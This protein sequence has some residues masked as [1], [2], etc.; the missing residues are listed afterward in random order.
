MNGDFSFNINRLISRLERRRKKYINEK[1]SAQGLKG[2]M[3][4][5]LLI[6]SNNP[7]STQDF[8]AERMDMD[9]SNVARMAREL[10]EHGYIKRVTCPDNRRRYGV[11]PTDAGAALIAEIN[12]Q[13]NDYD[14]MITAGLSED[15]YRA[16]IE[17]LTKMLENSRKKT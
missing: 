16:E 9:K 5:F 12:E 11:F 7:G 3:F 1:F 17:I 14:R 10:E 4:I 15:E 6:L 8:M 13:L 2:S